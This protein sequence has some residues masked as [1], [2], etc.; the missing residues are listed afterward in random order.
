[1]HFFLFCFGILCLIGLF[2]FACVFFRLWVGH[3]LG[4]ENLERATGKESV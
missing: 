1:M 3:K 4:G 2:G